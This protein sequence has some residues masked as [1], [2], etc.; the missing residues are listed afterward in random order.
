MT[1]Y[2]ENELAAR[3]HMDFRSRTRQGE[4]TGINPEV[5]QGYSQANLAILPKEYAFEFLLFCNRNPRCCPIVKV[6][7]PGDPEPKMVAPGTDLRTD[8]TEVSGLGKW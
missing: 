3:S 7:E 2:I 6:T 5:C 1:N 8:F 4:W